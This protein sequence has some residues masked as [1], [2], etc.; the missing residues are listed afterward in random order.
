MADFFMSIYNN[1]NIYYQTDDLILYLTN[2]IHA[3]MLY[4]MLDSKYYRLLNMNVK[5]TLIKNEHYV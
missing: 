5:G 1:S 2:I 4:K 3:F